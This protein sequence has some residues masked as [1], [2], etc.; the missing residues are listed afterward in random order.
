PYNIFKGETADSRTPIYPWFL[1]CIYKLTGSESILDKVTFTETGMPICDEIVQGQ[2]TCFYVLLA[3]A[4]IYCLALIPFYYS[5]KI[6]LHNP[7]VHF[8]TVLFIAVYFIPHQ[9]W[10][11]TEP[12]SISGT[13]VFFSLMIFYLNKPRNITA[14]LIG[15]VTLILVFLRPIFLYLVIL[16]AGFWIFRIIVNKEDRKQ[17]VIGFLSLCLVCS[18]I[19]GY[20]KLNQK[21]HDNFSISSVSLHNRFNFLFQTGLY[22]KS[23]DS[24]FKEY[25]ANS[26]LNIPESRYILFDDLSNHFGRI[27]IKS[28]VNDTIKN[29][30][31]ELL[32]FNIKRMWWEGDIYSFTPHYFAGAFD[33]L[34]LA[35]SGFY[36]RKIPWRRLGMWALVFGW[37]FLMYFGC[38]DCYE[39]LILPILPVMFI[40]YSRYVDMIAQARVISRQEFIEE[41]RETL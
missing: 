39:R 7:I 12:L 5:S 18:V 16:L 9:S 33:F 17:S 11:L 21:N 28:F 35:L 2:K 20:A 22:N 34:F 24:E 23:T 40:V 32:I 36:F 25:I 1:K 30:A 19:Y 14:F 38:I 8:F 4:L 13:M 6:L 3:Q 37:F 15:L 27:R 31:Y 29:N 10:I 41:L 26:P